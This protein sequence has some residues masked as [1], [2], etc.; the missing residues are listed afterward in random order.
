MKTSYMSALD[1]FTYKY[2][3]LQTKKCHSP[4]FPLTEGKQIKKRKMIGKVLIVSFFALLATADA[5]SKPKY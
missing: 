4:L 1:W 2:E 5:Q 3:R